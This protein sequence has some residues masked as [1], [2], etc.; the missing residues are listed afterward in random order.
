MS[1]PESGPTDPD[2]QVAGHQEDEAQAPTPAPQAPPVEQGAPPEPAPTQ[3]WPQPGP[4]GQVPP[5][6]YPQ[7]PG[8]QQWG[9]QAWSAQPAPPQ[10]Q[11]PASPQAPQPQAQYPYPGQY[12]QQGEAVAGPVA[13]QAYQAAYPPQ[14]Q[15]PG[16]YPQASYPAQPQPGQYA[17]P[18]YPSA[19]YPQTQYPQGQYPTG[20]YPQQHYPGAPAGAKSKL[21]LW[22]GLGVGAVVVVAGV[23]A[24]VLLLNRGTTL[25]QTAAQKGVAQV[26]TGSYGITNITDVSCPAGQ[27]VEKGASFTCTLKVKGEPQKVTV[28]F[29]D[30]SGTYEVGR[31]TSK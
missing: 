9:Q 28:T 23:L 1:G 17:Q 14:Q 20:A 3:Q 11:Q 19:Q 24:A 8:Q 15:Y 30:D 22:I 5:G 2:K 31:P 12:P 16:P 10:Y 6:Q 27:K 4:A 21:P 7:Q 18:Q 13:Q 29:T 26:L 25:D